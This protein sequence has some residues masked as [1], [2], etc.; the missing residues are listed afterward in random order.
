MR[1]IPRRA[2]TPPF[3]PGKPMTYRNN[4]RPDPHTLEKTETD[5]QKYEK[6]ETGRES[7]GNINKNTKNKTQCHEIFRI[8]LIGKHTHKTLAETVRDEHTTGK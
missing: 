1:Y 2:G 7:H 5:D 8:R 6:I 4:R 3:G